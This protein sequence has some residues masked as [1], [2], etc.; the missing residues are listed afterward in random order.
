MPYTLEIL[1]C[2][3]HV[4]RIKQALVIGQ[5]S[6]PPYI[7]AFIIAQKRIKLELRHIILWTTDL[8]LDL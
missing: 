3:I 7:A 1:Q 6:T 5:M 8:D 2:T 4:S